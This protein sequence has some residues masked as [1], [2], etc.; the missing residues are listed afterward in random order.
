M[1]TFVM[2]FIFP[3]FFSFKKSFIF[4]YFV[5]FFY[6]LGLSIQQDLKDI[7]TLYFTFSS[8]EIPIRLSCFHGEIKMWHLIEILGCSSLLW[9][10]AAS[11]STLHVITHE[12]MMHG[13]IKSPVFKLFFHFIFKNIFAKLRGSWW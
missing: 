6:S 2:I 5:F 1:F 7:I 13:A 11:T 12:L 9:L 8:L 4:N 3:N 10:Q